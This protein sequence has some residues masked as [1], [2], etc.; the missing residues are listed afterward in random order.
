MF[1]IPVFVKTLT[2][3]TI[4]L[5]VEPSDTIDNVKQK[6]QDKE[7]IPPDQQR[8]IFAGKQ[9]EDGRTLSDYNIQKESTLHL[10]L[11]LRGGIRN[12]P[13]SS[14]ISSESSMNPSLPQHSHE[15]K[16]SSI[17]M[18]SVLSSFVM[19]TLSFFAGVSWSSFSRPRGVSTGLSLTPVAVN[20]DKF[21]SVVR[22]EE[23][24]L[25]GVED[26]TASPAYSP[27]TSKG[28]GDGGGVDMGGT[29]WAGFE[30]INTPDFLRG[31]NELDLGL[32]NFH[33]K[34]DD[35]P[36]TIILSSKAREPGMRP[37]EGCTVVDVITRDTQ[38]GGNNCVALVPYDSGGH[39]HYGRFKYVLQDGSFTLAGK[40]PGNARP[41]VSTTLNRHHA[42]MSTYLS[43]YKTY[44][45]QTPLNTM[46]KS[47]I[48]VV[49]VCNEGMIELLLNWYCGVSRLGFDTSNV[50]IFATDEKSRDTA[51]S[52]GLKVSLTNLGLSD[53]PT[54]AAGAYGDL[55]FAKM[56]YMKI[57]SVHMTVTEGF[58]IIFQDL[59]VIW[60]ADP[61]EYIKELRK[62]DGDVD[63]YYSDDGNRQTRFSPFYANTGFYY[64]KASGITNYFV[65]SL[66]YSTDRVLQTRTHQGPFNDIMQDIV[67]MYGMRTKALDELTFASGWL[68]N[69]K[70]EYMMKIIKKEAPAPVVFHMCWTH[71]MPDKVRYFSQMGLWNVK[72][73]CTSPLDGSE[74]KNITYTKD[75]CEAK[76]KAKCYYRDKPSS[77]R[78]DDSPSHLKKN[79]PSFWEQYD[80]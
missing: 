15:F 41:P 5:D 12:R 33:N 68:Y 37:F 64:I 22:K 66:L 79:V 57:L 52:L 31:N 72:E 35:Y 73:V 30:R 44:L 28:S 60:N 53:L 67:S 69:N 54:E 48:L 70:K 43:N 80:I 20:N 47:K 19:C 71:S 50:I 2:G 65:N 58:D 21:N 11:R 40:L 23:I 29:Y 13:R 4:T 75:C 16:R 8:L 56:M 62:K 36:D 74:S 77:I 42:A 46:D 63:L 34:K 18:R 17:S 26:S 24:S 7:G 61:R 10:V 6:I 25:D 9:L 14:L 59:D 3:K 78:C 38:D 76:P 51:K 27:E 32:P 45:S 49:M 55:I 1:A 39:Y